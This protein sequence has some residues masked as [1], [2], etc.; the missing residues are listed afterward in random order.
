VE[1]LVH[2]K[3][4]PVP[5]GASP[6]DFHNQLAAT[7]DGKYRKGRFAVRLELLER[8]LQVQDTLDKD[9][10]DAGCGTG[11]LSRWLVGRGARI[12]AM[13]AAP[14][15]VEQA[16]RLCAGSSDRDR[17]SYSVGNVGS[18][19]FPEASF[20]GV[21]CSSVL[22]YVASPEEC[23]R[24]FARVLRPQGR[25]IFSVPNSRS[26]LRLGLRSAYAVTRFA[27][28]A[29]PQ[30][31]QHSRHQFSRGGILQ[32]LAASGFRV[33]GIETFGMKMPLLQKFSFFGP[34]WM[35]SAS[36]D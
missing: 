29:W 33:A 2:P 30:W 5:M 8:M 36:R 31:L 4:S 10:L 16:V 13:D 6:V 27:G 19:P 15:M 22:E 17:L 1:T 23:L 3:S 12:H 7:W 24:E 25:L 32:L 28:H 14:A 18:L 35:I 34:L 11:I 9:W 26:G 20:D 21:L